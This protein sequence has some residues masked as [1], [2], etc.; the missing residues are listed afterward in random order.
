[1]SARSSSPSERGPTIPTDT[2]EPEASKAREEETANDSR[3]VTALFPV[4]RNSNVYCSSPSLCVSRGIGGTSSSQSVS[5][6]PRLADSDGAGSWTCGLMPAGDDL[7]SRDSVEERPL[8]AAKL[9]AQSD[10]CVVSGHVTL[11]MTL[12]LAETVT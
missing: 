2:A 7:D 4:N 10:T 1:M 6:E 5:A 8:S 9:S 11:H 3:F 12:F